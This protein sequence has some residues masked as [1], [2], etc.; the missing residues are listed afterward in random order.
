MIRSIDNETGEA[1]DLD[2]S[3]ENDNGLFL[4]LTG[5]TP[6]GD[7]RFDL[8]IADIN[9]FF[10]DLDRVKAEYVRRNS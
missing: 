7:V 10:D 5:E 9:V 8:V 4:N 3:V 1:V 2:V 6:N